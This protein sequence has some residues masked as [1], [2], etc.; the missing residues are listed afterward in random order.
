MWVNATFTLR[1][2]VRAIQTGKAK[3]LEARPTSDRRQINPHHP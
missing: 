3:T 1:G 2:S